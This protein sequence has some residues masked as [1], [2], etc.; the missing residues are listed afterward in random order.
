MMGFD[1][2]IIGH[3]K[4]AKK[5]GLLP[6]REDIDIIGDIESLKRK[7]DL[8]RNFWNYPALAAFHSKKL[9]HL[10]YFSKWAKLLHDVMYTF[11]ERPIVE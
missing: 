3:L 8:K 9:T 6:E 7:F 2:R 1:W 4:I 5:Y 10:F 11:R